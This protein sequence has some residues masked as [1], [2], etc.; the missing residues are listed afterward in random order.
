VSKAFFYALCGAISERSMNT[1]E[2]Y[3]FRRLLTYVLAG[4]NDLLYRIDTGVL[5]DLCNA[6]RVSG[7]IRLTVR[8]ESKHNDLLRAFREDAEGKL[9]RP[10]SVAEAVRV[11]VFA[12]AGK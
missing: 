8:I 3:S 6:E 12:V 9:G 7:D 5:D 4:R 2:L 11:C 10:V 1:L